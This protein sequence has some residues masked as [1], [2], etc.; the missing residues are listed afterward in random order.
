MRFVVT[1]FGAIGDGV[2]LNNEAIE[3]AVRSL[4]AAGGGELVFP[5][6][7]WLAGCVRLVDN[8]KLILEKGA[9]LKASENIQDYCFDES[10]D[11][12]RNFFNYYFLHGNGVRNLTITGEGCID[13]SGR[14]F[15]EDRYLCGAELGHLPPMK[16]VLEYNVLKPKM[17]RPVLL[18]L[19]DC[20]QVLIEKI[21]IRNAPA[22]TIWTVSCSDVAIAHLAIRNPEYGPNTDALDIDCCRNVT[23]EHCDIEAG[24][25]C[26]ALKSDF[27]RLEKLSSCED[28]AIRDCRFQSST[29]GIRIGYEGDGTIRNV[30]CRNVLIENTR[31]GIDILS[32]APIC[33]LRIE[34]GTP[35]DNLRFDNFTMRNVGQ[36]F[37]IWAG[38]QPPR[39]GHDVHLSDFVF[40]N[41]E[42]D[43]VG[44]S[45][46]GSEKPG[47]FSG[48]RFDNVKMK[49]ADQADVAP[50]ADFSTM[51]NHWGA[52]FKAG[53]LHLH[54]VEDVVIQECDISCEQPG[55]KAI[56]YSGEKSRPCD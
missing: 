16:S 31:H 53:G 24:D 19:A 55:F 3:R 41:M 39:N 56:E 33:K 37:F 9:V 2:V 20:S 52:W 49:V 23:I 8:M 15:W 7:V 47:F 26:V 10:I 14:A 6:G 5:A 48:F 12:E 35:M 43:A 45:F 42:I 27:H 32:I 28:I 25:D 18:Y 13:G 38:N 1:D 4:E 46:I 21:L 34:H 44:T 29:C 30:S 54:N 11:I 17:N 40:S 36:A 22:Y 51:P 50:V